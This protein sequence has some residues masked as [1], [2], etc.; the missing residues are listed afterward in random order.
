[1]TTGNFSKVFNVNGWDFHRE[2][3]QKCRL[4]VPSCCV[5]E[6]LFISD[7]RVAR[8]DAVLGVRAYSFHCRNDTQFMYL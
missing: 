6:G 5:Y 1:M 3:A 4:F 7:G 2:L 8:I